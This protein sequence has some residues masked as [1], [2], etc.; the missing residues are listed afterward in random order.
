VGGRN[1]A[2]VSDG[3]KF[4]TGPTFLRLKFILDE[5]FEEAG[6]RIGDYAVIGGPRVNR[7]FMHREVENIFEFRRE[8]LRE[9]YS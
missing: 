4:D 5:V 3:Y 6:R 2:I 1:A 7:L 8:K 9:I